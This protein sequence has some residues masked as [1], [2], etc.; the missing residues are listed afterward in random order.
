LLAWGASLALRSGARQR[1][2]VELPGPHRGELLAPPA[3][4]GNPH[5]AT[6]GCAARERWPASRQQPEGNRGFVHRSM[7]GLQAL[8]SVASLLEVVTVLRRP[9]IRRV[10]HFV[11]RL[12][13]Q[14]RAP[15]QRQ[16]GSKNTDQLAIDALVVFSSGRDRSFFV[17]LA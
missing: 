13:T 15:T 14:S 8:A 17:A 12:F 6:E 5:G 10:N 11:W 7:C 4:I 1:V 2:L 16:E 3:R 9:G